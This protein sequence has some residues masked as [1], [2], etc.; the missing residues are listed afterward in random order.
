MGTPITT[1]M[2]ATGGA[3]AFTAIDNTVELTAIATA[4]EGVSS[5]MIAQNALLIGQLK[6]MQI[7]LEALQNSTSRAA[8]NVTK[9]AGATSNLNSAIGG[10]STAVTDAIS[11]QQAAAASQIK[12]NNFD[13]ALTKRSLSANGQQEVLTQVESDTSDVKS[14]IKQEVTDGFIIHTETQ[15]QNIISKKISDSVNNIEDWIASSAVYQTTEQ[16]FKDAKGWLLG[17]VLGLDSPSK[18]I[19]DIKAKV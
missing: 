15:A 7:T 8:D 11:T 3:G 16:Y 1:P 6:L 17:D 18:A 9:I 4:I 14:Q 12:K 13:I 10:V 19:E 5:T 2:G